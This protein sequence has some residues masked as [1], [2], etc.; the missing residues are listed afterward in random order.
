M[1]IHIGPYINWVGPYQIASMLCFWAKP[2]KDDLGIESEPQWVHD[3]GTWLSGGNEKDSLLMKACEWIHS[4]RKRKMKV[5][6]DRYDT[7]NMDSTLAVIILPMLKQLK[8]TKHGSPFVDLED[9]PEHM[10][11]TGFD[12]T[13]SQYNLDFGN[14]EEYTSKSWDL[15]ASRWDLVLDEMIWA[16]EQ[17]Q[18]EC[19]WEA[20]YTKGESELDFTK[21]PED[22]GK[23]VVPVRWKK[24][25][26]YDWE[27][28]K[29]HQARITNGLRLFG[30]YYQGLWT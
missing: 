7:W 14:N 19:D 3:F 10:R 22:E 20:Q 16:F 21:Y 29:A 8:D 4:K 5:K 27:G 24:K 2:E 12:D 28:M 15:H 17:L 13:S 9:L 26:E 23:D 25:A 11:T 30:V 18:P 6:L 1:R